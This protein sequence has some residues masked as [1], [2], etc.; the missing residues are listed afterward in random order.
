MQIVI[1]ATGRNLKSKTSLQLGRCRDFIF[2]EKEYNNVKNIRSVENPFQREK[3]A[4]NLAAQY[5]VDKE[6][7]LLITGELGHVAF[8]LLKNAKIKVYRSQYGSVKQNI[9]LFEEDKLMEITNLQAG[10]PACK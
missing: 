5:L 9:R 3:G 7:D 4:G 6:I 10:F 8:Q 1:A 2:L